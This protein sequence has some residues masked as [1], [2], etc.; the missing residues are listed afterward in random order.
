MVTKTPNK[1]PILREMIVKLD[2]F[3]NGN[4]KNRYSIIIFPQKGTYFSER[5]NA[6]QF[7]AG[8]NFHFHGY[9][10]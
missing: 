8:R 2:R 5:V 4:I 9:E 7:P 6:K 1:E 3:I 10:R